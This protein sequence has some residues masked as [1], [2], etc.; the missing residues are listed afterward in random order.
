MKLDSPS[1]KTQNPERECNDRC[2]SKLKRTKSKRAV[3][4]ANVK[5]LLSLNS[6]HDEEEAKATKKTFTSFWLIQY[7]GV[8]HST[9]NINEV[10][11]I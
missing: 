3:V 1:R 11:I 5:P 8:I 7:F 4:A 9:F 10:N 6:I 2:V